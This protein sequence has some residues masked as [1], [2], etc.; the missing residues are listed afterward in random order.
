MRDE[1]RSFIKKKSLSYQEKLDSKHPHIA[2]YWLLWFGW[3]ILFS[4][5]FA[6]CGFNISGSESVSVLRTGSLTLSEMIDTVKVLSASPQERRGRG[7]EKGLQVPRT[8]GDFFYPY[9]F[10]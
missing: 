6:G 2:Y 1:V 8:L 9:V 5:I 7:R 10:S 4:N 3:Q